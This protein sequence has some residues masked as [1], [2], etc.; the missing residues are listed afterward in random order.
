MS[1]FIKTLSIALLLLQTVLTPCTNFIVSKGAST[2]GSTM[3]TYTADSYYMY[4]ELYH[5]PAAKYPEGAMLDIYEWDTGKYLGKIKQAR[6]TYNVVGNMNEHQVVIGE[7]TFGGRENLVNPNG[8]IDYGSLIYITLQRAK[9]A[10]EA[11]KIMI[12]L[13]EEYGYYSEGE[14]FSIG[15]ANEVWILEMLGKGPGIKGVVYAAERIPDG[16][17]SGHANQA[18]ITNINF[19]DKDNF[20]CSSDVITFAREKGYFTGKDSE[21][22]FAAAYAPIDFGAVRFCDARVW[23]IFRRLNPEMDSYIDYINGKSAVR[24]PLYIKPV[25]KVS[26]E[27]VMSL[28]RDHFEGTELDMTKGLAASPYASPYRWRPLTWNCEGK[29]YFHERPI[30]TPQT[31]FSFVSQSRSWL[32]NEVGGVLWFGV[33]DSY[34]TVYTPFYSSMVRLPFNYEVGRASLGKFSWDAA[35]WVFNFVSNYVYPRYSIMIDDVVKVRRELEGKYFAGQKDI[36]DKALVLSKTS[37]KDAVELLNNYSVES[38]GNTISRWKQLGE[39]LVMKYMDGVQKNEFT[40]VVNIGYPEDYR[41]MIVQADGDKIKMRKIPG[42]EERE[43]TNNVN[44][45]DELIKE[46]KYT[47]ASEMYKKALL[48][49]PGNEEVKKKLAKLEEFINKTDELYKS[50]F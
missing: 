26:V 34:M 50:M 9:S 41:K 2:D 32:P 33:D 38:A 6:E 20:I 18:R 36:E 42:E 47:D 46:K 22:D 15:D 11:I 39:Y 45:A 4:G 16:Y 43:F 49:K 27:D 19:N 28:M 13:V 24:M 3:I 14:S 1:S 44:K 40:K 5:Y 48:I 37:K 17:V 30:S 35:F 21:F 10:R 8:I 31:G 25:K 29:E 12:S 23:S 7:T